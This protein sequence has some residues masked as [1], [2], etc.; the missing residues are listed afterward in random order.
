MNRYLRAYAAVCAAGMFLV[1]VMGALVTDT[2]SAHGCGRSWPLCHGRL[3]PGWALQ[4]LI[5]YSHRAIAGILGIM[6]MLL[7]IWAWRRYGRFAEVKVLSLVGISFVVVQS[8][9]GAAAVLWPQSPA[10][11]ALHFGFS[12][13]AFAGVLLLAILLAQIAE[14]GA[15]SGLR[16]LPVPAGLARSG[17]W[18]LAYTYLLVYLGAYVAHANAGLAC[19]GW[20]L[21]NGQVIPPLHGAVAV[22]F[23]HRVAALVALVWL[24]AWRRRAIARAP[25][26]TDLRGAAD[27]ALSATVLQ[28]FSG[29][30]LPW[31]H[32]SV[33]AILL[34]G[35]LVCAMFGA[36][37]YM[38]LQLL[39]ARAVPA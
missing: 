10:I 32:L 11:L 21:C 15:P 34:H 31:T 23:A 30:L 2:G 39:P 38:C 8:L 25:E 14:G 33:G 20:P 35:T 1:V 27:L 26:R 4:T 36:L 18:L 16:A 5:E 37:T 6:I 17:W 29:A 9:L 3:L 24:G 28:I 7:G 19:L 13:T 12:L 22:V